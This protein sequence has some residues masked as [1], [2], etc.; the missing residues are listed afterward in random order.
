MQQL[1]LL[2]LLRLLLHVFPLT[3]L[4]VVPVTSPKQ[5]NA[6]HPSA[7]SASPVAA[8]RGRALDAK[9][10]RPSRSS[11]RRRS[12]GCSTLS[13]ARTRLRGEDELL[14][15]STVEEVEESEES[16]KLQEESGGGCNNGR[17]DF[18]CCCRGCGCSPRRSDYSRHSIQRM[19]RK[20][21]FN[22]TD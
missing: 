14:E 11:R 10:C 17:H 16:E 5:V 6:V 19:R 8:V 12:L 15:G 20:V 1:L 18:C 3:C 4:Q 9:A 13:V 22:A 2:L 7:P 21:S